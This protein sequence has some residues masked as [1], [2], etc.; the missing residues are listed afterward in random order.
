M[1]IEFL[2]SKATGRS[3][4]AEEA[5]RLALEATDPTIEV[6][7]TEVDGM[8]DARDK[9]FLGSPSIRVNGVDVEYG[10]REPDEYQSGARYYNTPEGWKPYPH[11]RLIA[12]TILELQ[13]REAK[14]P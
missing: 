14:K 5:L 12:N 1:K 2:Y 13:A 6:I 7:Y 11:A 8:E 10:E 9:K 4:Q 3:A